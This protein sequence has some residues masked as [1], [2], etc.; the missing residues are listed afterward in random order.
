MVSECKSAEEG[1]DPQRG[2]VYKK[3]ITLQYKGVQEESNLKILGCNG[4]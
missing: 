2:K 4:N 3:E 1:N